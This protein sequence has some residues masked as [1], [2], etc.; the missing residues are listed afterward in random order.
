MNED[1]TFLRSNWKLYS[2]GYEK[3]QQYEKTMNEDQILFWKKQAF[4]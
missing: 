2:H 1:Q 4:Y 3:N